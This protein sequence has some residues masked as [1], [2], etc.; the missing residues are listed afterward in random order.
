MLI[1]FVENHILAQ[2]KSGS[3][4]KTF[5]ATKNGR[6]SNSLIYPERRA[7]THSPMK[8]SEPEPGVVH[9]RAMKTL[10]QDKL[11]L[12]G[13]TLQDLCC[14]CTVY[15]ESQ[16]QVRLHEFR[17]VNFRKRE[18]SVRIRSTLWLREPALEPTPEPREKERKASGGARGSELSA[19]AGVILFIRHVNELPLVE[20]VQDSPPYFGS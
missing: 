6:K 13:Q 20:V 1:Q 8:L 5:F 12:G 2:K 18:D 15:F 16:Q 4:K 10:G 11:K 3:E 19:S 9:P 14:S 7:K 17:D